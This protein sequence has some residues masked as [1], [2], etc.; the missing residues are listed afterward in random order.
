MWEEG[1]IEKTEN[2]YEEEEEEQIQKKST[3]LSKNCAVGVVG[4]AVRTAV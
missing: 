2:Y 1:Q 4:E 3:S